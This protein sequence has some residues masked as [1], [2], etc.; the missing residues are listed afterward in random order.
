MADIRF[1]YDLTSRAALIELI[2]RDRPFDWIVDENITFGDMFFA[3]TDEEPGRT[4]I[5][6][7][8]AGSGK[9][10]WLSYRRLDIDLVMREY[11]PNHAS[12]VNIVIS[13]TIT[14]AKILDELNRVFDMHL[15]HEDVLVN[16]RPLTTGLD[17]VYTLQ[18][19]PTSLAYYGYVPIYVNTSPDQLDYRLFEDGEERLLENGQPRRLES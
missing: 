7:T 3:P 16:D 4:F 10:R 2:R 6:M 14:S 13:G 1:P 11:T 8:N 15:N 19:I 9:K 18:I 12:H 5:E 17:V